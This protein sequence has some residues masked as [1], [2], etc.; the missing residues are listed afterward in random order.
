MNDTQFDTDV[1]VIFKTVEGENDDCYF[2]NATE[3]LLEIAARLIKKQQ[4]TF[5]SVI[6]RINFDFEKGSFG[7]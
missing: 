4:V 3:A 5:I 6:A 2:E 7:S 1:E